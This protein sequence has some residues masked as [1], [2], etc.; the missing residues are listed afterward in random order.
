MEPLVVSNMGFLSF[1]LCFRHT[2]K[3]TKIIL[4]CFSLLYF[5]S[6]LLFPFFIF[7]SFHSFK[8]WRTFDTY[9]NQPVKLLS[10]LVLVDLTRFSLY[11]IME[12]SR[13]PKHTHFKY[14]FQ[15]KHFLC[16]VFLRSN[17]GAVAEDG[18]SLISRFC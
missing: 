18:N 4:L 15:N 8:H 9:V 10:P 2:N 1:L 11:A 6:T 7:F 16:A 3:I 14:R 13:K 17:F 12:V 5:H